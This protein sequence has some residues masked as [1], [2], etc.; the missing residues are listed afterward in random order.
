MRAAS[1]DQLVNVGKV[2]KLLERA[3]NGSMFLIIGGVHFR[4]LIKP[5]KPF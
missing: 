4:R 2:D 3:I 5:K 1:R